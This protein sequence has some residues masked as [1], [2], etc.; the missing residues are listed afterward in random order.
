M[1]HFEKNTKKSGK[2]AA[3]VENSFDGS[4]SY[5]ARMMDLRQG[6]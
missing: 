1:L 5:L 3:K 4:G 2:K 6:K